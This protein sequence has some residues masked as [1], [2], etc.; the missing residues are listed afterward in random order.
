VL[1]WR[2]CRYD[3]LVGHFCCVICCVAFLLVRCVG[4]AFLLYDVLVWRFCWYDVLVGHFL[5]YDMWVWRFCWYDVS[6]GHFCCVTMCWFSVSAGTMCHLFV[7]NRD[8]NVFIVS[9]LCDT[10]HFSSKWSHHAVRQNHLHTSQYR[11]VLIDCVAVD[12][13]ISTRPGDLSYTLYCGCVSAVSITDR[14]C[15]LCVL[16]IAILMTKVHLPPTPPNTHTH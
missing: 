1:V 9:V 13:N 7:L 15:T 14:K 3:V 11:F 5:W 8:V 6:V 10:H 4:V 16:L 2:F 12:F